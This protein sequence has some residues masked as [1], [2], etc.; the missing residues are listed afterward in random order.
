MLRRLRD[1]VGH[2]ECVQLLIHT[3]S[4]IN[5][6]SHRHDGASLHDYKSTHGNAD[7]AGNSNIGE[8]QHDDDCVHRIRHANDHGIPGH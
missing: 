7:I 1:T 5:P 6:D 3:D 8:H 4:N 2:L